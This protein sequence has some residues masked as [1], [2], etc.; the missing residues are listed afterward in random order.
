MGRGRRQGQRQRLTAGFLRGGRPANLAASA[1]A[2]ILWTAVSPAAAFG[3]LAAAMII[4]VPL[5]LASRRRVA[6]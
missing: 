4:A 6:R 5:V 1:V 2:G 3:F